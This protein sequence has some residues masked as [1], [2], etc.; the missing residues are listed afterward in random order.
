[1]AF[2]IALSAGH[3]L[4][5][6]GR[7]CPKSLDP[8]E[9]RE[10]WLNHRIA[11]KVEKGLLA[12]TGWELLRADDTT[13]KKDIR[14]TA[15]TD[16]ANRWKA[17]FYLSIHHN[18]GVCGGT[19]GGIMAYVYTKASEESKAWQKALYDQLIA[20]TGLRGNRVSP[21]AKADLHEC[22][23][24]KMPAVLL[25]LGFMDSRTDVPV[26]LTETY[27][28]QCAEAIVQVLAE[29]GKLQKKQGMYTLQMTSYK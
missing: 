2:K 22:R 8:D 27:A 11:D 23:Q 7:R 24:T 1:M 14:L 21:L 9:T 6:P 5:T 29:R 12:Y 17:D 28:D 18:A 25:E 4:S 13:G 15:R 26:I 10:W 16:S 20:S 19:G 3:C